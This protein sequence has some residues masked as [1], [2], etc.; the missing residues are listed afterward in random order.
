MKLLTTVS[1]NA[2]KGRLDADE[3][4]EKERQDNAHLTHAI[5]RKDTAPFTGG[6]RSPTHYG[7]YF[8]IIMCDTYV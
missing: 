7:R 6:E 8:K 2:H 4:L 5:S 3:W 1:E